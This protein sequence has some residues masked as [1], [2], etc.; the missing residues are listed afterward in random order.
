MRVILIVL[1]IPIYL[2]LREFDVPMRWASVVAILPFALAE[3][4]GRLGGP[5]EKSAREV[6][7]EDSSSDPDSRS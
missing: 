2:V 5:Y 4:S 3:A 6:M 1:G 7:M